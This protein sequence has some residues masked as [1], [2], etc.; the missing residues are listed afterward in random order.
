MGHTKVEMNMTELP[1]FLVFMPIRSA[2]LRWC[3]L[4]R[5]ANLFALTSTFQI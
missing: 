1:L 2:K 4:E 3:V 5:G